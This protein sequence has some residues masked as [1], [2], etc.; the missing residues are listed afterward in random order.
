M[1]DINLGSFILIKRRAAF[2]LTNSSPNRWNRGLMASS[3]SSL[4][5]LLAWALASF[6][7]WSTASFYWKRNKTDA[8]SLTIEVLNFG[9]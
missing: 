1:Y 8:F 5:E 4:P 7:S 2:P 3:S 9:P 6:L